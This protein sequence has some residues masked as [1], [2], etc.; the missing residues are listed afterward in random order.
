MAVVNVID[1]PIPSALFTDK[2]DVTN[3][4]MKVIEVQFPSRGLR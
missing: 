1:N 2:T 3:C 4:V